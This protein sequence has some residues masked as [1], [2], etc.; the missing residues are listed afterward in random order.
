M[1]S[2]IFIFII[3][4]SSALSGCI[5]D[6]EQ[7]S[8][9]SSSEIPERLSFSAP[10][11]NGSSNI[12]NFVLE[13]YVSDGPVLM[14]RVAAG[15]RGCHSWTDLLVDEV[16]NGNISE[17]SLL[18]VHRYSSFESKSYVEE[19]YGNHQN[20]SNP[21]LWPLVLPSEDTV[22]YDLETGYESNFGFYTSFGNP[23]TPTLQIM[24]T[25]GEIIWTS[26]TYWPTLE[27]LEEIKFF[28][29]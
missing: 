11:L 1:K 26:K 14:L 19:V 3:L 23:P 6:G 22:V 16:E 5:S 21:V 10:L 20:S 7:V 28:I 27:V 4:V 15:C 8:E 18:S 13:E 24:D 9:D 12:T 29:N 17:S 25:N 2:S